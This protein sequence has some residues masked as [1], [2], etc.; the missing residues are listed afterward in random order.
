MP[1]Q[2]NIKWRNKDK[3]RLSNT[4]RQFNAKITGNICHGNPNNKMG[5]TGN[6]NQGGC[7][8]PKK[9]PGTQKNEPYHGEGNHGNYPG[10]QS[11]TQEV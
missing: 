6:R 5:E 10:K 11:S 9:K 1:R 4:V 8:Q 2:Y 3:T 7:H